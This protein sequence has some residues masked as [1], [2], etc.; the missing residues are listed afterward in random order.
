MINNKKEGFT[1]TEVIIVIAI[2]AA[3]A[4]ILIPNMLNMMPDD[5]NIKYKK[6]FFTIQEVVNDIASECQGA[7]Y[8]ASPAEGESNWTPL[9]D[10][11]N[12]LNYCYKLKVN[13]DNT[14]TYVA[15]SL[16]EEICNRMNVTTDDCTENPKDLTSTNGMHWWL[17][18]TSLNTGFNSNAT[19]Y[20]SVEGIPLTADNTTN[21]ET[22]GTN[23]DK[24][25]YRILVSPT[26]KV[27]APSTPTTTEQDYL[28]KNPTED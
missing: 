6:A 24:G 13:D 14:T 3:L 23:K 11:D 22:G 1:L 18:D 17:P 4:L 7:T 26:G 19:I 25:I 16:G 9:D 2:M 12:V 20:V 28:L 10:V 8:N 15:R 27:S 21:E 5:H